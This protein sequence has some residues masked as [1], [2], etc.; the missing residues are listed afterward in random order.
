MKPER[1]MSMEFGVFFFG[2]IS[3]IPI[4]K[5]VSV[6]W[7]PAKKVMPQGLKLVDYLLMFIYIGHCDLRQ[8]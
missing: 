1:I 4:T 5:M 7:V 2:N 8:I 3:C 6:N